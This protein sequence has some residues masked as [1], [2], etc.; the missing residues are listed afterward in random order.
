LRKYKANGHRSGKRH[1]AEVHGKR[2]TESCDRSVNI[3]SSKRQPSSMRVRIWRWRRICERRRRGGPGLSGRAN[4]NRTAHINPN[5]K[6][7]TH[8]ELE[9]VKSG[10]GRFFQSSATGFLPIHDE[11][12][13]ESTG[14]PLPT[15]RSKTCRKHPGWGLL[16]SMHKTVSTSLQKAKY[17]GGPDLQVFACVHTL[18]D[19]ADRTVRGRPTYMFIHFYHVCVHMAMSRQFLP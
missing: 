3:P 17:S 2:Y 10:T 12:T 7:G 5:E 4:G 1:I 19:D 9:D 13:E 6:E 8:K 18:W 16:N 15:R 11:G 14:A